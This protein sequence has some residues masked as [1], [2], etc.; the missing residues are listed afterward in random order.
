[1]YKLKLWYLA[2]KLERA[3]R[4][5]AKA[6]YR[7]RQHNRKVVLDAFADELLAALAAPKPLPPPPFTPQITKAEALAEIEYQFGRPTPELDAVRTA[8]GPARQSN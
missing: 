1:M 8:I 5:V 4:D 2:Y 3:N 7:L 6:T